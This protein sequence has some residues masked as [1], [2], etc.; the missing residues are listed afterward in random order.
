MFKGIYKPN[1]IENR[2][3]GA[4]SLIDQVVKNRSYLNN[5]VQLFE[6]HSIE[7]YL[8]KRA[9]REAEELKQALEKE[10]QT[11]LIKSLLHDALGDRAASGRMT[12]KQKQAVKDF[13][14][15]TLALFEADPKKTFYLYIQSITRLLEKYTF[16]VLKDPPAKKKT[17][18]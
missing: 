8:Q 17:G 5:T 11:S 18:R 4:E 2:D 6:M 13:V 16:E 1:Q 15:E 10:P 9:K 12:A 14:E 3:E 7:T